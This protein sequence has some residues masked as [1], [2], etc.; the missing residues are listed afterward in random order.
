MHCSCVGGQQVFPVSFIW[1][2]FVADFRTLLCNAEATNMSK[3]KK[4]KCWWR[5]D[6]CQNMRSFSPLDLGNCTNNRKAWNDARLVVTHVL[7][8]V[9]RL[10]RQSAWPILHTQTTKAQCPRLWLMRKAQ[11][12]DETL[13]PAMWLSSS[14]GD[15]PRLGKPV[16]P[17]LQGPDGHGNIWVPW[18]E[19]HPIQH[20]FFSLFAQ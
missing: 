15:Q 19:N 5:E 1:F 4:G 7:H 17:D 20:I 8:A 3:K 14:P 13:P 9:Q 2:Y 18:R 11:W 12:H 16:R 10:P 6:W